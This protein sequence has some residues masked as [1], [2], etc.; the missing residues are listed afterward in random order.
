MTTL[1]LTDLRPAE[2][3]LLIA[4]RYGKPC[5]LIDSSAEPTS[6]EIAA[7]DD[8]DREIRADFLVELITNRIPGQ[9]IE[10]VDVRGA[11]VTGNV[12]VPGTIRVLPLRSS[13]CRY[14]EVTFARGATFTSSARFEGTTFGV[15]RFD[16]ATFTGGAR[17]GG[18]TFGVARFGGATFTGGAWFDGATF[19]G[20]ARFGGAMF[21]RD[22]WFNDAMF[23]GGVGFDGAMFAG[24]VGFDGAMFAGGV[25][26]DG[27]TFTGGALFGGATF[28]GV[29]RFDGATFTESSRLNLHGVVGRSIVFRRTRFSG[30]IDGVWAGQTVVFDESRFM[31]PVTVRVL[32]RSL[33]LINTELR[34]GGTLQVRGRIDAT[35]ATFGA[36][37]TIS[38]PGPDAWNGYLTEPHERTIRGETVS[39]PE[40]GDLAAQFLER[41]ATPTSVRSLRRST[42]ADLEL[43]AVDLTDCLFEGAH[44]LD[45][46]RFDSACILPSTTEDVTFRWSVKFTGRE[47]IAEELQWR[48][49]FAPWEPEV[50]PEGESGL[51]TEELGGDDAS[52]NPPDTTTIAGIYRA[53]RKGR[54]DSSDAPG[55][56]D[57]YYGEMEMRRLARREWRKRRSEGVDRGRKPSLAENWLLTVY[58]AVSGYGLRAWRSFAAIGVVIAVATVVF[59]AVGVEDPPGVTERVSWVQPISG[60]VSYEQVPKTSFGLWDSFE[61]AARNSVALLRNPG[62]TPNLTPIGTVMDIAVRLLVPV[63]LALAVLAIRGRTKR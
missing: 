23:A 3:R 8:P 52:A 45:K 28:T 55:A 10:K 50:D 51:A 24:G 6:D 43:S 41:L 7:W 49:R 37:T 19:T 11:I 1:D 20:G 16:G 62:N 21:S 30:L 42:V 5:N 34:S 13:Y 4:A 63:L 27:A 9:T 12:D 44:G 53:L 39:L 47:A 26:F 35:A 36:R 2:R 32:C 25:G 60:E 29:A 40:R 38:D 61:L 46:L 59:A 15:A 18:A 56:A 22:A 57:F 14:D 48:R 17:F 58:W 54:E 33:S 31:E